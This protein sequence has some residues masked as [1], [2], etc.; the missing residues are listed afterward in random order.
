METPLQSYTSTPF[1]AWRCTTNSHLVAWQGGMALRLWNVWI[2][3]LH[4]LVY[5]CCGVFLISVFNDVFPPF[6]LTIN[7][8]ELGSSPV[9]LAGNRDFYLGQDTHE[10]EHCKVVCWMPSLRRCRE[11]RKE[12]SSVSMS[13]AVSKMLTE[14]EWIGQKTKFSRDHL[15]WL[16]QDP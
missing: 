12:T 15:Y 7:V 4:I 11:H 16:C 3:L 9:F 6:K 8:S 1:F 14:N 2:L 5:R 13:S 10:R